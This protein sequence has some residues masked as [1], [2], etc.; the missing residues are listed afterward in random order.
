MESAEQAQRVDH[1]RRLA[2]Q[3]GLALRRSLVR[4]PQR[5]GYGEYYL[6]AAGSTLKV[7]GSSKYRGGLSLEEAEAWLLSCKR[8]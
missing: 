8:A 4:E 6:T 5:R 3:Q 7:V 2:G 1:V